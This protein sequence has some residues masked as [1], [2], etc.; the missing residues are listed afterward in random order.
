MDH[1]TSFDTSQMCGVPK[2]PCVLIFLREFVGIVGLLQMWYQVSSFSLG[3]GCTIL[4]EICVSHSVS[5]KVIN[6]QNLSV[7]KSNWLHVVLFRFFF[8]NWRY[9][10]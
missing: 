1:G 7:S 3:L 9:T 8:T 6:G 10:S 4:G 2:I 5:T